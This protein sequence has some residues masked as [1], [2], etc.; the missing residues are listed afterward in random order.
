MAE[1]RTGWGRATFDF[2]RASGVGGRWGLILGGR[3][4]GGRAIIDFARASGVRE[5]CKK[6]I[7]LPG[8]GGFGFLR[9]FGVRVGD[10]GWLAGW[11]ISWMAE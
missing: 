3:G 2:A 6:R 4:L 10:D 11:Q 1:F 8:A 5:G 9:A 7:G